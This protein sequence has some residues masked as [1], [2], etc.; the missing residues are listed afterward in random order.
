MIRDILNQ[1]RLSISIDIILYQN[2]FNLVVYFNNLEMCNEMIL[3]DKKGKLKTIE[4]NK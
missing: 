1:L 2:V 3:L 4:L